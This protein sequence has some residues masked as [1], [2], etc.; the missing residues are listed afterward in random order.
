MTPL[1]REIRHNRL[2]WVLVFVLVLFVVR[3]RPSAP[4]C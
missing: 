2:L 4:R 3:P 1:L